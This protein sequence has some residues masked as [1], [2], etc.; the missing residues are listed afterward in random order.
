MSPQTALHYVGASVKFGDATRPVCW[1]KPIDAETYRVVY[2]D[3][4][5]RTVR[6]EDLPKQVHL[7]QQDTKQYVPLRTDRH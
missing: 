1:Y 3:L 6:A 7:P 2:G 4:S 5:I